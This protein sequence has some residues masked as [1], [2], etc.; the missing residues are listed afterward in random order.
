[1]ADEFCRDADFHETPK[2]L[3]HAVNQRHG[4]HSFTTLPKEGALRIFSPWK[5]RRLR[6]GLNPQ[7]WVPKVSA[8]TPKPPKPLYLTTFVAKAWHCNA[9]GSIGR[10]RWNVMAHAQ[11][12]D[13]VF[14]WNGRVHLNRRE[15]SVYS[16]TGNRGV[17]ISGSNAG[18]IMFRGSAKSTGYPLHSPVSP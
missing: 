10:L 16:T 6:P 18:Y 7:T 3:L 9:E 4:T 12:P 8:L 14:R 2:D 15:A 1:M 11:K 13:F 5:I 17:R